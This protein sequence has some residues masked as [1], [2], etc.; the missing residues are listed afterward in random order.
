M[1]LPILYTLQ[2]Y[3]ESASDTGCWLK[4][5]SE[6]RGKPLQLQR[7]YHNGR[8]LRKMETAGKATGNNP[9]EY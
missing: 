4:T 3:A 2:L 7:T 1:G 8:T 9:G 5:V 6:V